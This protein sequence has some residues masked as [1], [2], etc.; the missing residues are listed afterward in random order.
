MRFS[1]R[2]LAVTAGLGLALAWAPM[3]ALAEEAPAEQ[4]AGLQGI[5]LTLPNTEQGQIPTTTVTTPSDV[6]ASGEDAISE[7]PTMGSGPD[8]QEPEASLPDDGQ[9]G[10]T[11]ADAPGS[12]PVEGEGDP[13]DGTQTEDGSTTDDVT[14]GDAAP[15][16][17]A[18]TPGDEEEPTDEETDA[19]ET[20]EAEPSEPAL[21]Q[22]VAPT[23]PEPAAPQSTQTGWVKE[24]DGYA[25]YDANG[26]RVSGWLVTDDAISGAGSELQRYWLGENGSLVTGLFK[27]VLDGVSSWFYG[28]DD[29]YV[30]R[31]RHEVY[32]KETERTY[33]YLADNDGRLAGGATGG[34]VVSDDYGQALATTTA[35]RAPATGRTTPPTRDTSCAGAAPSPTGA[36]GQTT[37]AA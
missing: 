13:A 34:W 19:S 11:D 4:K 15:E 32:D 23:T 20:I 28:T 10:G 25:Y 6:P 24:G 31:D 2:T 21:S 1:G 22:P 33:V 27:A 12:L 26:S 14:S 16:D 30:V 5:E 3:T 37:T 9:T 8:A 17:G 29:G 36:T 7:D 18:A 35:P